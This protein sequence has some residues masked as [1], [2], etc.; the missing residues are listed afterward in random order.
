MMSMSW[1]G[2]TPPATWITSGSSKQRTTWQMA[3]V[4]ADVAE[5]LVAEAFTLA[6]AFDEAGDVDELH[7]G[8]DDGLGL[9]DGGDFG[10]AV[11][12]HGDDADVG[13]DGAEGIVGRLRLGGGE[14]VEDGGFSHVGEADDSA[15]QR[16]CVLI[17]SCD[18][19][20]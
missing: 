3:S 7:G 8:G 14:G 18:A 16:H 15:V 5:E 1:R 9:D 4:C 12:G 11:V 10:E 19:L 20:V 17:P 2:L 13:V 6:G